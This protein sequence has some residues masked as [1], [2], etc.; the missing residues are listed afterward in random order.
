MIFQ[1]YHDN[2]TLANDIGKFFVQKVERIRYQLDSTTAR[3]TPAAQTPSLCSTLL[4][5]F[6]PLTAEEDIKFLIGKSRKKSCSLDP[7]PTPLVVECLDVLLPVVSR[8]INSS[9]QTGSF[10]DT[11]KHADVSPLFLW[12]D[13]TDSCGRSSG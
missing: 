1:G 9:L 13:K 3:S 8:M 11:W 5:S 2:R 6:S 10:P 4:S 12:W 7:M